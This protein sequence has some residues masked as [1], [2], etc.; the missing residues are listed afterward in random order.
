M[1]TVM[2]EEDISR[3]IAR[4]ASEALE[5]NDGTEDLVIVGIRTR[6]V[7]VAKRMQEEIRKME[8][9]TVPMGILDIA[10]QRDD[11]LSDTCGAVFKGSEIDFDLNGK[12]V[13][14]C[15]DVMYTGRTVRAAIAALNSLGRAKSVQLYALVDR[16]HRE[17]PFRADAVGKNVPISSAEKVVA[18]F[19][20]TDGDE[21]VYL[22][23][24]GEGL[25]LK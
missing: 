14:L 9:V 15:D 23:K 10:L 24:N 21:G 18:H 1:I 16:G 13:A 7:I 25:P 17:L 5:L 20:E 8:G 3:A 19:R 6:G 2:K 12:N 4:I 22:L 11:L